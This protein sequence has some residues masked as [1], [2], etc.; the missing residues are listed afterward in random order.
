MKQTSVKDRDRKKTDIMFNSADLKRSAVQKSQCASG[1]G[2]VVKKDG[3]MN[4]E[5][6]HQI[7][8]HRPEKSLS[9]N[10]RQSKHTAKAAKRN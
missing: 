8:I 9:A 3:I 10:D 7:L 4:E 6:Y 5:M 1:F 2:D